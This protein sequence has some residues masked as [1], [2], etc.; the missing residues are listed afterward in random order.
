MACQVISCTT[1][2]P[3]ATAFVIVPFKSGN[4]F[5]HCSH[6]SNQASAPWN[7]LLVPISSYLPCDR[8]T[9]FELESVHHVP[10]RW[11]ASKVAP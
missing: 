10:F 9:A 3:E 4:A 6:A 7:F 8:F 1:V 2:F 11:A 5:L